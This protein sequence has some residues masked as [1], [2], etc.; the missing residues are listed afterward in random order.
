MATQEKFSKKVEEG[1]SHLQCL[2]R[3]WTAFLRHEDY[4]DDLAHLILWSSPACYDRMKNTTTLWYPVSMDLRQSSCHPDLCPNSLSLNA[5][6][7]ET[8][9]QDISRLQDFTKH[10]SPSDLTYRMRA[11]QWMCMKISW[12]ICRPQRKISHSQSWSRWIEIIH[13][14]IMARRGLRC[15]D[16]RQIGFI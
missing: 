13:D 8:P 4:T 2:Q 12:S 5:N 9:W 11:S 1:T 10:T 6:V 15:K 7:H 3:F 14:R 16:S